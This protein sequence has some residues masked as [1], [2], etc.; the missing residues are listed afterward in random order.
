[1]KRDL[2]LILTSLLFVA[3][4]AI[5]SFAQETTGTLEITTKD[6]NGAIVPGVALTVTS[7][8]TTTGYR[9]TITTNDDGMARV[10]Q[11]PPGTYSVSAASS[12]G[13]AEK[14]VTGVEVGLGKTT[15]LAFEMTI[16]NTVVVQVN[17]EDV[18]PIDTN[19][20]TVENSISQ[21]TADLLPKGIGFNTI[22]NTTPGT[23]NETR[24]GGFQIDGASGSENTFVIDGQE[25]TNVLSGVL[26]ANSNIPFSQVQEVKVKNSGF[27]AEYGGAT[28][29]VVL[30]STRGGS[31]DFH[32]ELG[33]QFRSSKLEPHVQQILYSTSSS[34]PAWYPNR[35][36]QFNETN[37]TAS[38][39]GPIW[40]NHVYFLANYAPQILTQSRTLTFTGPSGLC[41]PPSAQYI[42]HSPIET[43]NFKQ[44]KEDALARID[45]Q[46]FNKLNL[47][48]KFSWNP[49]TQTGRN[50]FPTY[51]SETSPTYESASTANIKGGRQNS[52]SLYGSGT[53]NATN[54]LIITGRVGH[55]FLNEAL[56]SYGIPPLGPPLVVCAVRPFSPT[57]FPGGF[58]CV[59]NPP[60]PGTPQ[61]NGIISVAKTNYD[62]T[63]RNQYEGDATY[64][65]SGWGRH[66]LKGGYARSQI[67]NRVDLGTTD[68]ITLRSGTAAL[69]TVGAF[70]ARSIPSTPGAIGS[71]H[72]STFKTRGNVSS[73]NTALYVQ[74]GWNFTRRLRL[75]L[76]MRTEEEDVPSYAAGLAGIHFGFGDKIT[77][78]LGAA[79]DLTGDGKT[80]VSAFYGLFFDRFKLTLPRGSFGG[81]EFHDVF[82]EI[83]PGD[84]LASITSGGRDLI[85]GAGNGPIPG[86]ACPLNTLTPVVGRVRCDIDNRVS[87]NSGGPLTEVGGIDPNIK[88]F[89][90]RE[91]TFTFQ[92]EMFKNYTFSTRFTTKTVT[93]AIEDAGFPNSQGSEYYIIGN[94]GE[95]L[96]KEQAEMFG[97]QVLKPQRDYRALE[98]RFDRRFVDNYYFKASYT[99]SRL[100]GNYGGLASSDEEGR[101]DPNVNRYFDQPQ[102]GWTTLG[103]PDNGRLATDRPHVFKFEAAYVLNWS[104]FGLWKSNET[105]FGLF[106]LAQ[107]GT[108]VTSFF[109]FNRIEQ[110]ILTKRGDLGR[111]PTFTQTNLSA[112]HNIRFGRDGRYTLKLDADVLNLLNQHIVTNRGLNPD[113]QGGNLIN[114][115]IFNPLDPNLHLISAAETAACNGSQQCKL[116]T[117]YRNYQLNGS[118]EILA[119]AQAVAG[120]NAFYNLDSAYQGKRQIRYGIRFVF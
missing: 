10:L 116:I 104:K 39:S 6:A 32:G 102:A 91:I 28:G 100:Y 51:F 113:G 114:N 2:R 13:F 93:H 12:K 69:A 43:Y 26:D 72:L 105:E 83:F 101:T 99:F 52:M 54:N 22:L 41:G 96:Y 36:F 56:G 119:A 8:G 64:I 46:L 97:L 16:G 77:P 62:V 68:V 37:P 63:T 75:N 109:N 30:V 84:T 42:C 5:V 15:P 18:S 59:N 20:T 58:G 23:G 44:R 14:T 74:D 29:G 82:F 78:R 24:S 11:V 106:Q 7:S 111:T 112:T 48:G 66:E 21:R 45:A 3:L 87:S 55:Y 25:V 31:N 67:A 73:A 53:Y 120:H 86:G 117:A 89:T 108:V 95:G 98:F 17:P 88:P 60:P 94:P 85:F 40:R 76:G 90:Q 70:S 33:S 35:Y 103:G 9:R 79:Y 71:G 27:E 61:N 1:M 47:L 49:I 38:V 4:F 110:V 19:S 57:Q 34:Q 50:P 80:K 81:D 118:P 107:S 65:F 92:R 115:T